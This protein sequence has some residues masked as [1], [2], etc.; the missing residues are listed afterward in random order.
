MIGEGT[1]TAKI[2]FAV[3]SPACKDDNIGTV[4]L[5]AIGIAVAVG[6]AVV[7]AIRIASTIALAAILRSVA[8]LAPSLALLAEGFDF[9]PGVPQASIFV[10]FGNLTALLFG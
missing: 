2:T 9:G 7:I 3:G 5:V 4:G 10:G 1:A 8:L 6:I